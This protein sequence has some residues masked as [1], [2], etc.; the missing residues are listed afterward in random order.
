[1]ATAIARLKQEK[2]LSTLARNLFVIEGRNKAV[3][4]RRAE[5]ALLA[6]N[7]RLAKADGFVSGATVVV[8]SVPGLKPTERVVVPKADLEGLLGETARGL[9]TG[10]ATIK[11]KFGRS[12]EDDKEALARLA[13]RKFI[14]AAR[15]ALPESAKLIGQAQKAIKQRGAEESK[16]LERLESA[17][18]D[19]TS[20]LD[21]LTTLAKRSNRRR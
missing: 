15:K 2:R 16:R 6:A 1:M 4:Q 19:A 7:P 3:L 18:G 10:A 9:Q 12:S 11:E 20:E 21:R 13:N 5:R 14:A 17:I 8:P